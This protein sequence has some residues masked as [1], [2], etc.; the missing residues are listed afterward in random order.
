MKGGSMTMSGQRCASP[1]GE[2]AGEDLNCVQYYTVFPNLLLSLHPDYV[3]IHR[4]ERL[5]PDRSR[6]VCDW[7]FHPSAIAEPD[8]DPSGAIEFW[9]MTNQQDWHVSELSQKGISS[10]AYTPGPYAELESMIAAWDRQYL[11]ALG[12]GSC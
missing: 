4:I 10:R 3:L 9:N 1:L 11:A 8:F 7:L 2:L 5:A 12:T 6:I